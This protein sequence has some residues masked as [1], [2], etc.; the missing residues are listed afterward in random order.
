MLTLKK[1]NLLDADVEALVNAVNCVGV[2]GRGIA[3]QFKEAFP[4]NFKAYEAACKRGEVV[5]GR[6]FIFATGGLTNPRYI[7]NFPTKRHWREK[8]RIEDIDAGL[9]D[10]VAEVTRRNIKSIAIPP[11]GT[12]L[13]GLSWTDVRPRIMK[14]A[15]KL[16]DL[17]VQVFEPLQANGKMPHRTGNAPTTVS[18]STSRTTTSAR[19]SLA[20]T[21][22]LA[23]PD[24]PPTFAAPT[25]P[26]LASVFRMLAAF[27]ALPKYQFERRVDAL[28]TV[29]LPELLS[30]MLGGEVQVVAPE[31]PIKKPNSNQSTNIDYLLFRRGA[32]ANPNDDRWLFFELKTDPASIRDEQLAIYMR[33][34][35][36]GMGAL[37][38]DL[39]AIR[40]TTA[41]KAKYAALHALIAPFPVD[42]PIEIIL[43]AP[44]RVEH[45]AIHS[46]TFR[47]LAKLE[48][49]GHPAEWQLFR[50]LLIDMS[51][52]S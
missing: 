31:M 25:D 51:L 19:A 27:K 35:T 20:P 33:A 49:S 41:A 6:M 17:D 16:P 38:K 48:H 34:R 52:A 10:L 22:K 9:T 32:G 4:A 1:G 39:D 14:A 15:E 26:Y 18:P 3:L 13:G 36:R 44:N 11:L 2:M 12:G 23:L 37:L 46:I 30:R 7:V 21:L 28:L 42:V 29:F 45:P 8:S 47:D 43:L 5:P 40:G 24:A 50:E